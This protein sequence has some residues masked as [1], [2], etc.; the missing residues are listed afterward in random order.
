MKKKLY[1]ALF[2]ILL[3]GALFFLISFKGKSSGESD[4]YAN[5]ISDTAGI[6][7]LKGDILARPNWEGMP[8]SWSVRNG[9]RYGH[10]ALVTEGATGKTIEE[11]LSKASVV[12]AVFF[13]QGTRE[14]QFNKADQIKERKAIISFGK[15]FKGIRYRLRMDLTDQQI[16]KMI[17]FVRDQVDG[18]YNILSVKK[19]F[20]SASER[21]AALINLKN[22]NWHCATIIWEAFYLTSNTDIDENG[23]VFIYPADIIASKYFDLPGGRI[24][25]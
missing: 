6:T 16:E 3:I 13:D 14:F 23:G 20:A 12:E 1:A 11:A 15:R 5:L 22:R 10:A 25:F 19:R 7:L 24:C 18:G 21:E 8:G 17:K 2:V 9:R 4:Y